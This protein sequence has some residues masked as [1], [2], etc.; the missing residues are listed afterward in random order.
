MMGISEKFDEALPGARHVDGAGVWAARR[1][2]RRCRDGALHRLYT[3]HRLYGTARFHINFI[4]HH[5][6]VLFPMHDYYYY[7]Y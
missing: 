5:E 6:M 7:Y 4:H 1:C 3:T 2:T